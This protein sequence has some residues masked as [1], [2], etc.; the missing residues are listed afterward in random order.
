MKVTTEKCL[1]ALDQSD[2][3]VMKA[4]KILKLQNVVMTSDLK[5]CSNALEH[6]TWDITKAA[7]WILQQDGEVTQV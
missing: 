2:W 7:Q 4:I 1:E 3:D 5:L 6:T